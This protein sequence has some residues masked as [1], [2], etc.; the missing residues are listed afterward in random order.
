MARPILIRS[1]PPFALRVSPSEG[2]VGFV[3]GPASHEGI[4]ESGPAKLFH[5]LGNIN[6]M[7]VPGGAVNTSCVFS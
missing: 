1:F 3:T 4:Y 2:G 5:T 6:G 7:S